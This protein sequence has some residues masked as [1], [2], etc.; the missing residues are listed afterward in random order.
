MGSLQPC[1]SGWYEP[2]AYPGPQQP[3][4]PG[5]HD[6]PRTVGQVPMVYA[7]STSH[8]PVNQA[9]RYWDEESTPLFPFGFGLSYTTFAY[10]N[11]RLERPEIGAGDSTRL[12]VAD[13]HLHV[14]RRRA[15]V[16][17]LEH[18]RPC[19]QRGRRGREAPL[20]EAD[21]CLRGGRAAGGL[22]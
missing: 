12:L 22:L 10:T 2:S 13:E 16:G 19:D 7:H 3:H 18:H 17:H 11:I 4:E 9:K 14:M 8:E 1:C 6:E 21:P 15:G 20:D 5:A